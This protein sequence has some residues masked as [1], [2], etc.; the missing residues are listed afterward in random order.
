[1][2][3]TFNDTAEDDSNNDDNDDDDKR[4]HIGP[5]VK[6][7]FRLDYLKKAVRLDISEKS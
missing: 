4:P 7:D 1:M 3:S 2:S 5:S 6:I